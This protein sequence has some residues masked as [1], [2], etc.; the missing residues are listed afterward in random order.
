MDG[1]CDHLAV[2]NPLYIMIQIKEKSIGVMGRQG[3]LLGAKGS[4]GD[5]LGIKGSLAE[6]RGS[7][8]ITLDILDYGR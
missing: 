2:F 5:S 1:A 4:Q 3:M 7:N 6:R 8:F